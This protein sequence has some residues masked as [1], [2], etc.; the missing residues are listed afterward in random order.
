MTSSGPVASG[1][2]DLDLFVYDPTGVQVASSTNA[3]TDELIEIA[4]PMDGTWSVWVHGWDTV[5]PSANY[6]MYSWA[7]SATPGGNLSVDSAP[8][9]ATTGATGTVN[10]SWTGATAGQWH[11]G[12]VSHTGDAGLLGLTF[13]EVDNR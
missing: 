3:G 13:I 1:A 10:V 9:S 4:L 5:G 11:Y 2:I 7:I 12:A 8:A 6:D